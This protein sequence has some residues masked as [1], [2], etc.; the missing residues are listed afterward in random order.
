MHIKCNVCVYLHVYICLYI[1]YVSIQLFNYRGAGRS[2]TEWPSTQAQA[3]SELEEIIQYKTIPD[4]RQ[5]IR[6]TWWK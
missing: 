5:T 2:R 4:L 3:L 6:E 1:R